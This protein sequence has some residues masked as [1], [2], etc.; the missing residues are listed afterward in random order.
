MG[1]LES[2]KEFSKVQRLTSLRTGIVAEG[3]FTVLALDEDA[4]I[5]R[6]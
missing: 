6:H 2:S 5:G 4:A 3:V 1:E